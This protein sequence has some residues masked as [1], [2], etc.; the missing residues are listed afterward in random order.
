VQISVMRPRELSSH[1]VARWQAL[2]HQSAAFGHPCLCPEFAIAVDA[3]RPHARVA[4]LTDGP[5]T[6]GFFP[7]EQR[8]FGVGVPIG[9][10]LSSCQAVV[11][12]PG[13]EWSWPELVRGCG[14]SS[15]EFDCLIES[16]RP[17]HAPST[18]SASAITDLSG[19][20]C[21]FQEQLQAK[22]PRFCK[23]LARGQRRLEE[24]VGTYRVVV[25]SR[26]GGDLRTLMRWK[27]DQYRRTGWIDSFDRPWMV[28]LVES[29]FSDRNE[30]FSGQLSVSFA[31]DTPLAASFYLRS[32]PMLAGIFSAYDPDF[33]RRSPGLI[34]HL[35]TFEASAEC[36]VRTVDLGKGSE[37]YKEALKTA[38]RFVSEGMV[39][40]GPIT[41]TAH[42]ARIGTVRWAGPRIRSHQTA[43]R[44]VDRLLRWSGRTT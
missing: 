2:Q 43:F 28:G 17:S 4:L 7:F 26:D 41:A 10:S 38:D 34:H 3:F 13:L 40:R 9:T 11:H 37:Q 16:Q 23:N 35:R 14:L 22:A 27:S 36:G 29:L 32:G 18:F 19:G 5:H 8:R 30:H 31:H 44:V 24:E 21:S 39:A 42:R 15:W 25:D 12:A 6:V 33:A 1:D 20:F